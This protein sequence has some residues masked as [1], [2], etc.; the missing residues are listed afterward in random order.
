MVLLL[1]GVPVSDKVSEGGR[2]NIL[3]KY[4]GG[5]DVHF[6]NTQKKKRTWQ[7]AP[8]KQFPC[9]PGSP[10]CAILPLGRGVPIFDRDS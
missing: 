5:G 3:Q 7:N 2:M 6:L 4:R 10:F 8:F 1:V 9:R